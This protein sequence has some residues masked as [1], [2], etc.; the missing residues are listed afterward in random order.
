MNKLVVT[1]GALLLA[2]PAFSQEQ[3][4]ALTLNET[5]AEVAQAIGRPALVQQVGDLESWQYQIGVADH[6]DFSH[7]VLFR[8]STGKLISAAQ[9]FESPKQLDE[10]F[11]VKETRV[12]HY[13][14]AQ[15]PQFSV[16][17]RK[18][19]G[20]RLLLALGSAKPSTP[21]TQIMMIRE[22]ELTHFYTWIADQMQSE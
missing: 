20:G 5:R 16:R 6:D 22:S 4:V 9:T 2:A 3:I 12:Y 17:L 13:P 15:H 8:V 14:D 7:A 21:V 19:D 1:L 11:P 18:L 10:L